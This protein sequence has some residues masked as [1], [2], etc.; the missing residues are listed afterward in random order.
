VIFEDKQLGNYLI[1]KYMQSRLDAHVANIF[2]KRFYEYIEND[3]KQVILDLS[4][5]DF[6][7]SSGLGAIVSCLKHMGEEG[8]ISICC[9]RREIKTMF[10]LTRMDRVFEIYDSIDEATGSAAA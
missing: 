9:L 4:S 5:V 7:D 6:I 3:N 2:K 10:S 8:T 1:V